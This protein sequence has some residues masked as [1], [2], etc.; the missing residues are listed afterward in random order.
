MCWSISW[1][2]LTD[3]QL[4]RCETL[5]GRIDNECHPLLLATPSIPLHVPKVFYFII[6]VPLSKEAGRQYTPPYCTAQ[7][8][9]VKQSMKQVSEEEEGVRFGWIMLFLHWSSS[10]CPSSS[11]LSLIIDFSFGQSPSP[12]LYSLFAVCIHLSL[13]LSR[14]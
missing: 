6:Y 4:I 10:T 3:N 7:K 12:L 11:F 9:V 8:A 13:S 2:S 14:D 1:L 5:I